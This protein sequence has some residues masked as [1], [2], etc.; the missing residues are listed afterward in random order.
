VVRLEPVITPILAM[1]HTAALAVRPTVT[2]N[3][4][5]AGVGGV[6]AAATVGELVVANSTVR[7]PRGSNP[8]ALTF[9]S[10]QGGFAIFAC[11]LA[12]RPAFIASVKRVRE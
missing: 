6:P 3:A 11:W 8:L 5:M 2:P 7:V 1:A 10:D 4:P 9:T 12:R